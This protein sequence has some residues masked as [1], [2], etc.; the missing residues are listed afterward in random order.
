MSGADLPHPLHV[1]VGRHEQAV[2]PHDR[3]DD[4]GSD[5]RGALETDHVLE[6]TQRQFDGLWFAAAPLVEVRCADHAGDAGFGVPPPRIAGQRDRARGPAVVRAVARQHLVSTGD[7]PRDPDGVLVGLGA[8]VGE[9]ERVDVAWRH[10]RELRTESRP[11]LGGHEGVG[12]GQ[13]SGLVL[14]RPDH[15]RMAVPDI[16]AHQLAVEVEV[17]LALRRPEVHAL[18][19]CHRNG[20][21]GRLR[22]PFEDGVLPAQRDD[23]FA[24]HRCGG[25]D[26]RHG[27][28]TD[29]GDDTSL[30]GT[31]SRSTSGVPRIASAYTTN[32][33]PKPTN[34]A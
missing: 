5:V 27:Y 17:P 2:G 9:E 10:V 19:A 13:R 4:E 34:Q 26:G 23:L 1:A 11:R 22:R 29:E 31:P 15:L 14:D 25:R 28:L 18:R 20:I 21:D 24:G 32:A 16:G 33:T 3:L 6:F 12:V 7:H 30:A 8:A